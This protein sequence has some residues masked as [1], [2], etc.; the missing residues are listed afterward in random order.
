M[1][2][3][4]AELVLDHVLQVLVVQH[5]QLLIAK[6]HTDERVT[7]QDQLAKVSPPRGAYLV[8]QVK[9]KSVLQ[10]PLGSCRADGVIHSSSVACG[11]TCTPLASALRA[12]SYMPRYT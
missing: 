7:P 4:Q 3:C 12:S 6:L 10:A 11:C 2:G 1:H 5:D 8:C 9:G